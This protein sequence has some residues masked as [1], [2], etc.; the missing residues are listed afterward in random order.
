[1]NLT[2]RQ[3]G[4]LSLAGAA[5]MLTGAGCRSPREAA[6]VRATLASGVRVAVCPV[7]G[8]GRVAVEAVYA[9]GWLDEPRAQAAHMV[10]HFVCMGAGPEFAA[11]ESF[12]TLNR[13]GS[14]NAETLADITRYDFIAPASDL[15]LV[16][17]VLADRHLGGERWDEALLAQE[18]PRVASEVDA[19]ARAPMRAVHKF[20]MMAAGDLLRGGE[21]PRVRT[22]L[23]RLALDDL[24][25]WKRAWYTPSGLSLV[26]VGDV[27]PERAMEIFEKRLG[28]LARADAP[29]RREQAP[30]RGTEKRSAWDVPVGAA[31]VIAPAPTGPDAPRDRAVL[32]LA[33][34]LISSVAE[35]PKF[36]ASIALTIGSSQVWPV[37]PAPF[38]M[39]SSVRPGADAG[40]AAG[41]LRTFVRAQRDRI[42]PAAIR[43]ILSQIASTPTL[44]GDSLRAR[45]AEVQRALSV[46]EGRAMDLALGQEAINLAMRD[47]MLGEDAPATVR[48]IEKLSAEDVR[49]IISGAL[50]DDRLTTVT[51]DAARA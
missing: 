40:A 36:D 28:A 11:G 27:T 18:R 50:A 26:V 1:M 15:D 4:A 49:G 33:G 6:V 44:S 2:R 10:E 14:A 9:A 22:E 42:S 19:V 30:A 35:M 31:A 32:T 45:A 41:A 12:A 29:A 51:L 47:R 37:G 7:P 21:A 5:A 38:V 25:A 3:F 23:E 8:A 34:Q 48:A 17:R 20:A 46:P 39:V 13:V 16:A 24:R 43:L